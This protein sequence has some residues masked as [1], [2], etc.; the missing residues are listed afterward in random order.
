MDK[1]EKGAQL[2][3]KGLSLRAEWAEASVPL[4]EGLWE[5]KRAGPT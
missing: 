1:C 5:T 4:L 2:F 3:P